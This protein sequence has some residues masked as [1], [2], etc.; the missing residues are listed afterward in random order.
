M[1]GRTRSCWGG[2]VLQLLVLALWCAQLEARF[3]CPRQ[4]SGHGKCSNDNSCLC[5]EGWQGGAPDCSAREY[6]TGHALA[7]QIP[8][9]FALCDIS[10]ACVLSCITIGSCPFA[11]AWAGKPYNLDAAHLPAECANNGLC[12]RRTVRTCRPAIFILTPMAPRLDGW[13]PRC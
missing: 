4:C 11:H 5:Q 7:E 12:N 9:L 13:S 1:I 6:H 2:G 10:R 8:P 3:K